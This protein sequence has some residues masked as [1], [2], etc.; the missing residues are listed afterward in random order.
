MA[1]KEAT[2]DENLALSCWY[3]YYDA[4]LSLFFVFWN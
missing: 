4:V 1:T 3:W 2:K